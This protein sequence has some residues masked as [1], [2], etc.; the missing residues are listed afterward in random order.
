M[1][2]GVTLEFQQQAFLKQMQL[3]LSD[4]PAHI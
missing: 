1:A 4:A 3:S 2:H